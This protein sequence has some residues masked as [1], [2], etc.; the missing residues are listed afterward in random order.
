MLAPKLFPP[1]NT[2]NAHPGRASENAFNEHC[3]L[4]CR[5]SSTVVTS[6]F[7]LVLPNHLK[8]LACERHIKASSGFTARILGDDQKPLH[9]DLTGIFTLIQEPLQVVTVQEC[10]ISELCHSGTVTTVA[11]AC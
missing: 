7:L 1:S 8:N 5:L 3:L 9:E 11:I 4:L 6:M 2:T 10:C